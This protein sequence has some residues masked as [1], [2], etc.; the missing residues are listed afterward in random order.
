MDGPGLAADPLILVAVGSTI[1]LGTLDYQQIVKGIVVGDKP[2][3]DRDLILFSILVISISWI[4]LIILFRA[5]LITKI[6]ESG[7][8][9]K[10]PPFFNSMKTIRRE[11]IGRYEVRKYRAWVEFGG[12]GSKESFRKGGK[13]YIA[14]GNMGLQLSRSDGKKILLGTQKPD[15]MRLAMAQ[16][17]DRSVESY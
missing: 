8:H 17:M 15:L 9:F 14:K 7:I 6:T 12:Y 2:M 11:D 5:R 13:A 10:F 1:F 4:V 3:S 16:W